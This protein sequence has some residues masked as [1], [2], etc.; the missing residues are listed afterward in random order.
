MMYRADQKVLQILS[1]LRGG[2]SRAYSPTWER[3]EI[4][5]ASTSAI[6]L[7]EGPWDRCF[8]T[9]LSASATTRGREPGPYGPTTF[10][11]I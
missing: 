11:C 2:G 4:A 6:R 10:V 7:I 9:A 1:G 5:E 8:V 3:V